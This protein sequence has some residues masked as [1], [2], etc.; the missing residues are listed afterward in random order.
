MNL[1]ITLYI[2]FYIGL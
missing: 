2:K 1:H